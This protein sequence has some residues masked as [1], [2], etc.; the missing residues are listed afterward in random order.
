[1]PKINLKDPAFAA[2]LAFLIPGLGHFYQR[3]MFKA[4]LYSV[5]ILGTFFTGLRIGHGQV[6]YFHWKQPDN[7]T[8]AYLCQFWAGLP[9]LPALAQAQLRSKDS[10]DA[11][12]VASDFTGSFSGTLIDFEGKEVGEIVGTIEISAEPSDRAGYWTGTITGK[13]TTPEGSRPIVG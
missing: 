1:R 5:C 3:R 8:Y 2:F 9:A 10:F 7:R 4:L 6:V 11:N 12:Y 13:L